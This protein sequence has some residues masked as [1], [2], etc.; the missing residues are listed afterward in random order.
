MLREVFFLKNTFRLCFLCRK[1]Q[2]LVFVVK[3]WK[4]Q[5]Y[6]FFSLR[7]HKLKVSLKTATFGIEINNGIIKTFQGREKNQF[8]ILRTWVFVKDRHYTRKLFTWKIC[9]TVK[10]KV[11]CNIFLLVIISKLKFSTCMCDE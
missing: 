7:Y 5:F 4:Y 6:P 3:I 11:C 9:E 1:N 2:N 8:G 10:F